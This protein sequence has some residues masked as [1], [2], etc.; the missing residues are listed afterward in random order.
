VFPLLTFHKK[1]LLWKLRDYVN[2]QRGRH[3]V[4]KKHG[5]SGCKICLFWCKV[6]NQGLFRPIN[7]PYPSNLLLRRLVFLWFFSFPNLVLP[8]CKCMNNYINKMRFCVLFLFVY[9]WFYSH[10]FY[11]FSIKNIKI[12]QNV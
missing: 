8:H 7:I 9:L 6:D 3:R 2:G 4:A 5:L 10:L 11:V 12:K 1:R